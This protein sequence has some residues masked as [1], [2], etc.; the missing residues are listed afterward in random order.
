MARTT[1]RTTRARK[2]LVLLVVLS[3]VVAGSGLVLGGVYVGVR[4]YR[5]KEAQAAREE[6]WKAYDEGKWDVALA[7]LSAYVGAGNQRD[8][9]AVLR[10]AKARSQ[11]AAANSRHFLDAARFYNAAL[12]L[13]PGD[14]TAL[15]GLV[16]CYAELG[17]S[18]ELQKAAEQLLAAQ[19]GN[20]RALVASYWLA[21][22]KGDAQDSLRIAERLIEVEPDNYAWRAL[23]LE[24]MRAGGAKLDDRV[25]R[26]QEWI[27]ADGKD[28]TEGDGRYHLFLAEVYR[29]A[30]EPQK[31]A[32]EAKTAMQLGMP[33]TKTLGVL[34][35]LFDRLGDPMSAE[36]AVGSAAAKGVD[37][38]ALAL[39]QVNRYWLSGRLNEAT[40][41]LD[42][43][44]MGA[45]GSDGIEPLRARVMLAEGGRDIAAAD[46]AMQALKTR[47]AGSPADAEKVNPWIDAIV[48]TR[49]LPDDEKS[50]AAMMAAIERALTANRNDAFLRFRAG[51][52][53]LA[54]GETEEAARQFRAAY[55]LE[56]RR[57]MNAAIQLISA[58][59][60]L[61]RTDEAFPIA[62]VNFDR[63]GWNPAAGLALAQACTSLIEEGREPWVIDP[64][65]PKGMGGVR[66]IRWMYEDPVSPIRDSAFL[67]PYLVSA[68]ISERDL[69]SARTFAEKAVADEKSEANGL[70][71]LAGILTNRSYGDLP[72][73]A[74]A[75]AKARG[76]SA[77]DTTVAS[78]RLAIARGNAESARFDVESALQAGG[79]ELSAKDRAALA[80]VRAEAAVASRSDDVLSTLGELVKN[81]GGNPDNLLF[82]LA[83]Q[84]AW[85]DESFVIACLSRLKQLV[86]E[87]S[88][89]YVL[90]EAGRTLQFHRN[91]Q[92]ELSKA[93][94]AVND[95]LEGDPDSVGG[96]VTMSTLLSMKSP[97]DLAQ[98]AK[99]L[100]RALTLQPGR[101][102]LYPELVSLYQRTGDFANAS[103]RLQQ[104]ER[105]TENDPEGARSAA[106]LMLAQADY[107]SAIPALERIARATGA[108]ADAVALADAKRRTG[109]LDEAE[110]ILRDA[111]AKN[112]RGP[113]AVLAFAEFFARTGRVDAARTVIAEDGARPE[114]T[115]TPASRAFILARLELDYGDPKAAGALVDEARGL[116]PDST[117]VALLGARQKVATG[118]IPGGL[119][120]A[121]AALDK[122]PDDAALLSF[123]ASLMLADPGSGG[124]DEKTLAALKETNPALHD[125]VRIIASCEGPNGALTPNAD[126]LKGSVQLTERYPTFAPAWMAAIELHAAAGQMK[127][128]VRIAK[129]GMA[130]LPSEP[131]P[132]ELA[133]RLLMTE[134]RL[135]EARDAARSWRTLTAESPMDA[136]L[137]LARLAMMQGKAREAVTMLAP[138]EKRLTAAAAERADD[139]ALLALARLFDGN[140][141]EAFNTIKGSLQ[142]VP[143]AR[144]EWLRGLRAA[145]TALAMDAL[146]RTEPIVAVDDEGRLTMVAEWVSLGQRNDAAQA[147]TKANTLMAAVASTSLSHPLAQ[148]LAADLAAANGKIAEASAGYRAVLDAIPAGDRAK[149]ASWASLD[150]KTRDELAGP[151]SVY[152]YANN[153]LAAALTEAG[154]DL[155]AALAAV[156]AALALEPNSTPLLDTK[157]LVLLAKREFVE[158]RSVAAAAREK[159]PTATSLLVTLARIELAAGD[160]DAAAR[161]VMTAEREL[162]ADSFPDRAVLDKLVAVKESIA[163]LGG[164]KVLIND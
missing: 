7:K 45:D 124:N 41:A 64:S 71:L 151:R 122:H 54:L 126:A 102:E 131:G 22:S 111:C 18:L 142:T 16:E 145:P 66:I 161:H 100:E 49:A 21:V 43:I 60:A 101:R 44:P 107:G 162:Q 37:P 90:S 115:L 125:L 143:P 9:D 6:G 25:A 33:D 87:R 52:M 103:K 154:Q 19:P 127:E 140:V 121:R 108:E 120:L 159:D 155:D 63:Y 105:I 26:V 116:A 57:W 153:N 91:D 110:K 14:P 5:A 70:L 89:R 160:L 123:V 95:L 51:E 84:S 39:M 59:L 40:Q 150:A 119:A 138:Y 27:A 94:I 137:V 29:E 117:S 147:L 28:G 62:R 146:A 32:A 47:V 79:T 72:E 36:A 68:C 50:R 48:A 11:V 96:L 15:E 35:E 2:R 83:Q 65:L 76:A 93:V 97:P 13:K 99:F 135:D 30:G 128:A 77:I 53:A 34:V 38:V 129:R 104:Y 81:D 148:L 130:R 149:F 98:A 4:M 74:I 163:K 109:R 73:R 144:G 55:D 69:D 132:A 17:Y 152:L 118:D 139:L 85:T 67:L 31:A 133:A 156:E 12:E 75:A 106:R 86:G 61:G 78:A 3:S 24:S 113:L 114:P 8:G 82:V 134:R 88:P 141:E 136:D 56:D 20:K 23:A 157:A 80:R 46:R 158:A 42:A 10:L 112:T 164:S 92:N 1:K 58:L